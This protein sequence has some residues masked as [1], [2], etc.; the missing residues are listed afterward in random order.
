[1]IT[2]KKK[3]PD[4]T[5]I[6]DV[7]RSSSPIPTLEMRSL[8]VDVAKETSD[9]M[10]QFLNLRERVKSN[11][12]EIET[13]NVAI[14]KQE[15]NGR[16]LSERFHRISNDSSMEAT[17]KLQK[18][19]EI[20]TE[21]QDL[22]SG[23]VITQLQRKLTEM[24]EV[25]ER[26]S[27][28]LV[29]LDAQVRSLDIRRKSLL[30]NYRDPFP[31]QSAKR[32]S[33]LHSVLGRQQGIPTS[34]PHRNLSPSGPIFSGAPSPTQFAAIRKSL[35]CTRLS[36]AATINSHLSYPIYCLRFD[37]TGR[38]FITGADD[39]LIKV[40]YLGAGQ[41]C[42]NRNQ[43]DGSRQLKCSY[44]ANLPGAVLVCSL[45]GHA[46]VI[47]DIDVSA[48]NC[49]LATAS[50]DGD[51][52]VWGLKDG[53]PIAILR[54]H[55]GGA[56]MVSWSTLTPYRLLSTGS[57]GYARQWDV[58]EA[59]LKR[60]G[61][62]V[63]RREE[64]RLLLT[65]SEKVVQ[66][67]E[68]RRN[69]VS[70]ARTESLLP[71]IP[72]READTVAAPAPAASA[73]SGNPSDPSPVR[74]IIPPL[75][76]G[77]PPLPG[78]DQNNAE[79]NAGGPENEDA[80]NN[81]AP[82]QFVANDLI[83]EGVK[84]VEKFKH[85]ATGDDAAGPGT[86]ARRAAVKVICIARSPVGGHFTTGCDDGI[87]R[88]WPD[89]E[90]SKVE[91]VDRRKL[92]NIFVQSTL[93][94]RQ[95]KTRSRDQP[96]LQLMGHVSAITDL[97]YSHTGDRILSASQKEGVIRV[98]SLG[99]KLAEVTRDGA[100]IDERGISHIVIRLTNPA[101]SNQP[102]NSS[103]RR[104]GHS[105]Q[106]SASK[107]SCD[108]AVWSHDDSKVL[109]SQS[110]LV[111]QSGAE[112]RPGSQFLFLWD[113]LTGQCLMG[114][115]GA[116][117]MQ[118]PVVIPHPTDSSLVCTA[119]A[120]GFAKVWDWETGRCVFTHQNKVEFGPSADPSDKNKIA[121]YLDG[122]FS[123]DGTTLVLTDDDGRITILDCA[124]KT[125]L[126]SNECPSWMREQYFANDYY[127][128][129]Y[130]RN[131]YC[132]ERG[133]ERPPHLA[134]RGVRCNHSG[135][136][137]SDEVN[138][139]FA[140]GRLI[141]PMPLPA[142]TCRW[143]RNHVRNQSRNLMHN[144]SSTLERRSGFGVVIRRGVR[145]YDPQSTIMI[146]GTGHID[147]CHTSAETASRAQ[148]GQEMLDSQAFG[149]GSGGRSDASRNLSANY[150]W[151]DYDDLIRE[152]GNPD[153]DADSDD[154]E[155]E[156]TSRGR[157]LVDNGENSDED[158]SD[159]DMDDLD[160]DFESPHRNT[161][162]RQNRT[163]SG[164]RRSQRRAQRRDTQFVEIGSDDDAIAEF[165]STNNTPS[166]PYARDYNMAGHYWRLTG[167]KRV[168]R[169]WLS[170]FESDSSY[171]GR[172]T[173]TPQLGDSV[174]YIPRAHY[175]S[176]SEFP[177]LS[178]PWQRW[179]ESAAWPVVRCLVRGIRFRFPYEDYY[180]KGR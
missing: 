59:C 84:L 113:S 134:P 69:N 169:S 125:E 3:S 159:E 43:V 90:E 179:P 170:R 121:G 93:P 2:R 147:K 117:S 148:N 50:V 180:R 58:R 122:S 178:P 78:S 1:L 152:Q 13:L 33:V 31:S 66:D 32:N 92:E 162:R 98:W 172:K 139:A 4:S 112:V 52:R 102:K 42:R 173:Y 19:D 96:L 177:S 29:R 132:I 86:R 8:H 71:P 163:G 41:S 5:K 17:E 60:C 118:C 95:E 61:R 153:D 22:V 167:S 53:C 70:Q 38:Y 40:F 174:V 89:S 94:T 47:N 128:L 144:K 55:K 108:V 81:Q 137:Y 109:T 11:Q 18:L 176:I 126:E 123:P 110:V 10:R 56:N 133:S 26:D 103:R 100:R 54:G 130:D 25:Q 136:P 131:G 57:D 35:I 129:F 28:E 49:F 107:V 105:S 168:K 16:S 46:G 68:R 111:K 45:R 27:P 51:V 91:I 141:G 44:G 115:S 106:S 15:E 171:E 64:Y 166:G 156:P 12:R 175:E 135:S 104:P 24:Q 7:D 14:S 114:I 9:S 79:R 67:S 34:R 75:L 88:V 97:Y 20:K 30:R 124:L 48:D 63:G 82:G 65:A 145:E 120:D 143:R 101:S 73:H 154:E 150:Q 146:R 77:V 21:R 76:A 23:R 158:E 142:H 140:R 6:T 37:R 74:V 99:E 149:N 161:R 119:G 164:E 116:H 165:M 87:C 72:V 151:R 85:G 36:H 160:D 127:E 157:R 39:Y 155:F 138:E 80:D 62:I 83:D